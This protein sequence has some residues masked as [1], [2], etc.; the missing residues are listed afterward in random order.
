M[1]KMLLAV[2]LLSPLLSFGQAP[3]VIAVHAL[4]QAPKIDGHLEDWGTDGW[5][6]VPIKPALE[7][8]E[9][10][11]FGLDTEDDRNQ[12]GSL[13]LQL[14]AGVS[15]G[16]LYIALKYPDSAA[17]TVYRPWEW[18]G[19][20]YA[21]GKQREDMLALRFHMAGD[22]DRTMLS[23]KD[24]KV[25]VWLWSAARTNPAGIAEDM[26]HH[27]TTSML[28]NAAEY[29]MPDG[30]TSYIRKQRDAGAAPY[31]MLPRPKENKGEKLPAFEAATP[32]GSGADVA[33]KGDWKA[34]NWHLEFARVLS[35]GSPDDVAF[36]P[37]QKILGQIAVFNKGYAEHKSISEPLLFDFSATK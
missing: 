12:T 33:A 1:K 8:S 29:A 4:A 26:I 30:K 16:K 24:Y 34:G 11:K 9:R 10:A 17:D 18:R 6:K 28:E 14:K 5:I 37:G 2:A 27:V 21:E 20:K 31:K 3:Q 32:S 22:F 7:K 25:D 23:T 15:A 19:D 35:T 36:K 13:T